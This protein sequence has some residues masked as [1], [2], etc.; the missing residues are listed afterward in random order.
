MWFPGTLSLPYH[1][2]YQFLS[3]LLVL[4]SAIP[5]QTAKR[6]ENVCVFCCSL[7]L[8]GLHLTN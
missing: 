1:H 5:T 4:L 7:D 3:L 6:T 8:E 2:P